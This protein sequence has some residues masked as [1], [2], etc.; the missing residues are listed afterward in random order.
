MP[1]GSW[2]TVHIHVCISEIPQEGVCHVCDLVGPSPWQ[3][4]N[5]IKG[6]PIVRLSFHTRQWVSV[7]SALPAVGGSSQLNIEVKSLPEAVSASSGLI[8]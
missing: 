7:T 4:V 8:H 3:H 1:V 2:T 6:G 5:G